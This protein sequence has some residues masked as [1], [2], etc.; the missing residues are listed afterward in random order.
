M[1]LLAPFRTE[2]A[3]Q[4]RALQPMADFLGVPLDDLWHDIVSE[5]DE[6]GTMKASWL[7]RAFREGRGLYTLNF[8]VGWWIDI[9]ATETIAAVHDLFD[10]Q[11]PTVNS[12]SDEQLTLSH[13]TGEDRVLTT[14][15]AGM[16]RENV[17]LDDGTLPLGVQF[18]SKHGKPAAGSGLCWAYWMREVD[19]GLAEPTTITAS[20]PIT[21]AD[22]EFKAALAHCKIKSR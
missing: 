18:I 6:H 2:V 8:P 12:T 15:I 1:E 13:L 21:D 11:Y 7:P 20:E 16:L 10:G 4:R 9:T 19:S 3:G 5:W 17:E 22:P 14:A